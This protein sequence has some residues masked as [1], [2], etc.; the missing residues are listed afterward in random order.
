MLYIQTAAALFILFSELQYFKYH[1]DF[2]QSSKVC[3][4]SD[5][6]G[7]ENVNNIV[8]DFYFPKLK[9]LK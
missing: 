6:C 9:F 7:D 2:Y 3:N 5:I 8:K 4:L 1:E